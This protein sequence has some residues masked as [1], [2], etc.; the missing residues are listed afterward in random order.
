MVVAL[1]VL[2]VVCAGV[3]TRRALDDIRR[4]DLRFATREIGEKNFF[5]V[6]LFACE[7][8]IPLSGGKGLHAFRSSIS[9]FQNGREGT[10]PQN[11]AA[12]IRREDSGRQAETN[13]FY[14]TYTT[15]FPT[16]ETNG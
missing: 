3:R 16:H 12:L 7:A 6:A 9:Y 8:K 13:R 5:F 10:G 1:D 4:F 14:T 15:Y 11:G 2:T